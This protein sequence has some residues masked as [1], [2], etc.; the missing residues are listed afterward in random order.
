MCPDH[1]TAFRRCLLQTKLA[2]GLAR[3]IIDDFMKAGG[4]IN[5][6]INLLD[7]FNAHV[8]GIGVLVEAQG[9]K[10]RL[11]DEYMS[12]LTLSEIDM[13]EKRWKYKTE[14]FSVFCRR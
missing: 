11:V 6:M 12:L 8:A 13:K 4:T 3:L 1:P 9:V 14:I 10:E 7:E 2:D 5:G